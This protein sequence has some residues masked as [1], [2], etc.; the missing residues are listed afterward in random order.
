MRLEANWGPRSEIIE[1]GSPC[2]LKTFERKRS[3]ASREVQFVLQ[4]IKW[5]DLE[6]RSQT[7]KIES[8]LEE[9]GR[10]PMKSAEMCC[11]GADATGLG[12][13]RPCGGLRDTLF[14]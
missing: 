4:G 11:H 9:M 6:N 13:N 10:G 12:F 2:N 8:N 5:E 1:I 14:R 3:A 7:T